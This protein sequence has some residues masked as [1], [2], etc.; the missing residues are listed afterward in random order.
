METPDVRRIA[1]ITAPYLKKVSRHTLI[2]FTVLTP[3]PIVWSGF[4]SEYQTE[5]LIVGAFFLIIGIAR[6]FFE[7]SKRPYLIVGRI[8]KK[9]SVPYTA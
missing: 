2:T 5:L 4:N 7:Q 1:K 9:V 6:Y 3:A 8:K